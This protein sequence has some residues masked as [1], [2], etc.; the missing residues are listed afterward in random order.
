LTSTSAFAWQWIL[1]NNNLAGAI[2]QTL[3]ITAG[4]NYQ[5]RIA[6]ANG[7]T[8]LSNPFNVQ[9]IPANS[10]PQIAGANSFCPG[11]STILTTNNGNPAWEN[12][13]YRDGLILTGQTL[14]T[15]V[16]KSVGTYTVTLKSPRGCISTSL[17]FPVTQ[18][19]TP[20]VPTIS[21]LS[22]ICP[23]GVNVLSSSASAGNVW[24]LNGSQIT[25]ANNQTYNAT[26]A[27]SYTVEAFN[28]QGCK[29]VSAPFVL[30]NTTDIQV[31]ATLT[32]PLS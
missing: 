31:T 19:E 5:V 9:G 23:G 2:N 29:A 22:Q 26:V 17:P 30:S 4:G 7:C 10:T 1:N 20:A 32:D 15:L 21:G 16:V 13:W 3:R 12:Q 18:R 11:D 28:I 27:G 24:N 14:R 8:A 6:D 25:G